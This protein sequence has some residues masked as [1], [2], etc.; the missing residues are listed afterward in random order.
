MAYSE[1]GLAYLVLQRRVARLVEF[2]R[3]PRTADV[4]HRSLRAKTRRFGHGGGGTAGAVR[5]GAVRISLR[6][7]SAGG[8]RLPMV[9]VTAFLDKAVIAFL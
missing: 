4:R 8:D 2:R 9:G 7:R 1:P 6:R 5:R 3:Q